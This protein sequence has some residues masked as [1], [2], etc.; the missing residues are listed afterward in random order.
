MSSNYVLYG[1][2][3]EWFIEK[4]PSTGTLYVSVKIPKD[5]EDIVSYCMTNTYTEEKAA[6]GVVTENDQVGRFEVVSVDFSGA[7][8]LTNIG[9]YA[10]YNCTN[11]KGDIDMSASYELETIGDYAFYGCAGLTGTMKFTDGHSYYG[12]LK[13]IGDYAFY[14]CTGIEGIDMSK[15]RSNLTEIGDYAFYDCTGMVGFTWPSYADVLTIGESAFENCTSLRY[16]QS[17]S[18][19]GEEGVF[20]LLTWTV[21]IGKNAFNN[22]FAADVEVKVKIPSRVTTIG[23]F[24]FSS[25]RISQIV[26]EKSGSGWDPSVNY[27]GYRATAFDTG[28]SKLLVVFNDRTSYNDFKTNRTPSAELIKHMTYPLRLTF[29]DSTG[30]TT[31]T[32]HE[33]KLNFQSLSYVKDGDFWRYNEN[34]HLPVIT[35]PVENK[36]GYTSGWMITNGSEKFILSEVAIL[37]YTGNF[38]SLTVT[39]SGPVLQNPSIVSSIDGVPQESFAAVTVELDGSDHTVGVF[40]DHPLLKSNRGKDDEYVY[41]E[42]VWWD[43]YESSAAGPRSKTEGDLFSSDRGNRKKTDNAEIPITSTDHA[44]IEGN[45][46]MVEIYGYVVRDDEEELFYK[47][48]HNFID[49][50]TDSDTEATVNRC[51]LLQVNVASYSLKVSSG[52]LDFG[53][54]SIGYSAIEGQTI[55]ITNSG[56]AD[57]TL[58]L[59]ESEYFE[60]EGGSDWSERKATLQPGETAT[61]TIRPKDGLNAHVYSDTIT[62]KA[63]NASAAVTAMFE[64]K[65][66]SGGT[67]QY[68]ITASAG[69]GGEIDP[70]GSV[71]VTRGSSKTFTIIP[72]G[73]YEIADV[74]VD[75]NSV[76]AVS[77]YTFENVRASHTIKAVF[78]KIGQVADPDDT[79]VSDWLNTKDHLAYLAGYDTGAFGPTNNMTRAEAAQMFYN[80]LLNK[81]FAATVSFTDVA[82]DTWYADAVDTLAS[83]GV[84]KG[85]GN[86]QFA[87]N[88]A[89][90]R[91]EFTVIA[92]R[93]AELDTSGENIFTDVSAD[94]WF[95]AQVVGSIKYGWITGYEDGTFRPNN[96]ITRAEVTTIVNRMLGRAADTDYVDGHADELRQFPDVSKTNWAYYDIVEATN[97][98]DY[99]RTNS[100]EDWTDLK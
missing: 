21:E 96:T 12:N 60:I 7:E 95:Y 39:P 81:N 46:Y 82:E 99:A 23:D 34:Y 37:N 49:F 32:N 25:D 5:A 50:G 58:E 16:I 73:G 64:V 1:I 78:E 55:T 61:V 26:V 75:G 31:T 45:Y 33:N 18:G 66:T 85:V 17:S 14:G 56:T 65:E 53:S 22:C 80:L 93:F 72:A 48:H 100:G 70:S 54:A 41:F 6:Q 42:Y 94:D 87:P 59:P 27:A 52:T 11:M 79:G 62:F 3:K 29:S 10:F 13:S 28:S 89:I 76:G 68:T 63:G 4:N 51:Y 43:E 92:M 8:Y 19:G 67:T 69:T 20:T 40:V 30:G 84:I 15:A 91:A 97:A 98:H 35:E 24:A 83:I 36:T 44:R 74:L 9:D 86:D 90:T 47:S 71:R 88:R 77:S 57:L 38:D 2:S